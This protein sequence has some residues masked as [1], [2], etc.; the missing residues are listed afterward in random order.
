MRPNHASVSPSAETPVIMIS[1]PCS[2]MPLTWSWPDWCHNGVQLTTPKRS[3]IRS[4]LAFDSLTEGAGHKAVNVELAQ[5]LFQ[6]L[7]V[8]GHFSARAD[9]HP[10]DAC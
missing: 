10:W 2:T 3:A 7:N 1:K 5:C 4:S 9:V 6:D 8:L